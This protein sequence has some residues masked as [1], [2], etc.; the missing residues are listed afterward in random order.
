M[1]RSV[2]YGLHVLHVF[3]STAPKFPSA[4][5]TRVVPQL[6][7]TILLNS[8]HIIMQSIIDIAITRKT[9]GEC[10]LVVM[11][12]LAYS[13]SLGHKT[14]HFSNC[15]SDHPVCVLLVGLLLSLS[16]VN[17][18]STTSTANLMKCSMPLTSPYQASPS[19]SVTAALFE[20]CSGNDPIAIRNPLAGPS[21]LMDALANAVCS[22]S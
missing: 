2:T 17:I 8:G 18:V 14:P 5:S 6:T 12:Q 3:E 10:G 4:P 11:V 20:G 9:L 22:V 13:M 16:P 15:T 19:F 1:W 7:G 21:C